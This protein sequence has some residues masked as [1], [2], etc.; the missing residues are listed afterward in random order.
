MKTQGAAVILLLL[1]AFSLSCGGSCHDPAGGEHPAEPLYFSSFE[2]PEDIAGWS[3]ISESSL[4]DE[5]APGGGKGAVRIGGGCIQP[6]AQILLAGPEEVTAYSLSCWGKLLGD[7]QPGG[8]LLA[9]DEPRGERSECVVAI[10]SYE[11]KF[12]RSADSIIC[13][14]GMDL[15]IEAYIGGIIGGSMLVDELS[16]YPV[17]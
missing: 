7:S 13:P 6:A 1:A 15:R 9:T 10:D 4:V 16:V 11:W 8:L 5:A 3:G 2:S 12:Y 14:A 17:E